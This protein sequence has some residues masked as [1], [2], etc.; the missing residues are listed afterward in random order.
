MYEKRLQQFLKE[1]SLKHRSQPAKAQGAPMPSKKSRPLNQLIKL[2]S[3]DVIDI[4]QT[5]LDIIIKTRHTVRLYDLTE[6]PI[7]TLSYLLY[8]TQ[9]NRDK[10]KQIVFKTVPSAGATQPFEVCLLINRVTGIKP[11]LYQ[12]LDATHQL[13]LISDDTSL[14]TRIKEASLHDV[15]VDKAAVLYML[16]AH[17]EITAYRYSERAVRY[18]FMDSGHVMQNLYLTAT[19]FD[20]G[21]CAIGHYDDDLI[22]Q[23]LDLDDKAFVIYMATLGAP[24]A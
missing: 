16:I 24:H 23:A 9:G 15:M 21:M 14:M 4:P 18:L 11:G 1:S 17:H 22:N 19:Q 2:P 10:K 8:A 6:M 20:F 7:E 13:N 3:I 12:Y 5:P